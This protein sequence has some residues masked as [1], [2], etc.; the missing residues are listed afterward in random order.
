M[1]T[2]KSLFT[3][4]TL[5]VATTA[6]FAASHA[7]APVPINDSKKEMTAPAMMSNLPKVD[8]EVR[9]V[10]LENKKINLKHHGHSGHI[11]IFDLAVF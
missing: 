9:K 5:L 8:A 11:E 2:F 10:D 7:A 3:V 1:K 4:A 6:T